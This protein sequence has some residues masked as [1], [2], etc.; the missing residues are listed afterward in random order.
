MDQTFFNAI[1][2]LA[3]FLGG[4]TL[5]VTW[6]NLKKVENSIEMLNREMNENAKE[7]SETFVRKDD[8]RETVKGLRSDLQETKAEMKEVFREHASEVKEMLKTIIQKG[9]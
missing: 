7:A 5:K 8:Y 6:D 3:G 2:G 1:A 9:G 4:W